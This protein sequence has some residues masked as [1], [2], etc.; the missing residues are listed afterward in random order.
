MRLI[1]AA[2]ILLVAVSM[3]LAARSA[4]KPQARAPAKA[5]EL[6]IVAKGE[7]DRPQD[8]RFRIGEVLQVRV[9]GPLV[10]K[11]RSEWSKTRALALYF[12][13]ERVVKLLSPP[14]QNAAGQDLLLGFPLVRDAENDVNRQA[15][16]RLFRSKHKYLMNVEP[17]LEIGSELPLMVR[18]P[19]PLQFYVAK[20]WVVWMIVV[21]GVA[22]FLGSFWLLIHKTR[23][24]REAESQNFSLGKSQMAFWGLLV[25]LSFVGVWLLT[26]AMERIPPQALI[27]LG[28]S[29]ATGLSAVV[30]GNGKR[31][32]VRAKRDERQKELDALRSE[33]LKL[34]ARQLRLQAGF[35]AEDHDRLATLAA[36][37]DVK[38]REIDLLDQQ[39]GVRKSHSFWRD[40]CD[41]GGGMSFHRLQVVAWTLVLGVVFVQ[42]VARVMSMPEFPDSLLTLMGISNATYLGFK[43][44]EKS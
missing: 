8:Y 13:G 34:Q 7:G 11:I 30:I 41:D 28:I 24:L 40:I 1:V 38:Q 21:A 16:D 39:L 42:S 44:P 27:L 4:D 22:I 19:Y 14:R 5:A 6:S 26:G 32:G 36:E 18:S 2:T 25:V 23:M 15:W 20:N 43:F 37:I 9:R 10:D 31:A 17:S 3:P 12:D 35:A 29:G 33:E